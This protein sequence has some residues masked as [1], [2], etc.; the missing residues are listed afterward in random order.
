ML[1]VFPYEHRT[2]EFVATRRVEHVME[3]AKERLEKVFGFTLLPMPVVSKP[4]STAT[5]QGRK[6][7]S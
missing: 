6:S 1:I 4:R 2:G 7:T 5:A 3:L